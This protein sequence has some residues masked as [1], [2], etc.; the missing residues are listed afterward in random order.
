[1]GALPVAAMA[2]PKQY[3]E[4]YPSAASRLVAAGFA[5]AQ[6]LKAL[7]TL[8][9]I[10]SFFFFILLTLLPS[11]T[12]LRFFWLAGWLALPGIIASGIES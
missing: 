2:Y 7:G 6:V 9:R 3:Q 1:M 5:I 8:F 12:F 4:D 11:L 10:F